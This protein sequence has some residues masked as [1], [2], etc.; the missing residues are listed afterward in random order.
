MILLTGAAGFIGSNLLNHLKAHSD[1]PIAIVDDFCGPKVKNIEST[2][3]DVK[4]H[5]DQ[6][7]DWLVIHG[8]LITEIYHLGARTDTIE[9]NQAIFHQLNLN[10]S[11]RIWN[12]CSLYNV[13]LVYASS[14]ATYGLGELGFMDT[15]TICEDLKPL[16]PY[17]Q[18]KNEFDIWA[19]QQNQQPLFWAGIKFFNVY[20]PNETH[21]GRM[22][23]VI[24][25][26][27]H[28]INQTKGMK[29]FR[30]HRP[31]VKDGYQS[32]DFIY[33]DDIVKLCLYFMDQQPTSGLYNGGTG[34][35][36]T[37]LDLV[38]ATFRAMGEPESIQFIDTP[39]EIRH[40]YQY[41]TEAN[42]KKTWEAGYSEKMLTLEEGV[43]RYVQH[44]ETTI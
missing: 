38:K 28:Q 27:F 6:L 1:K 7:F 33:V 39:I 12:F 37:F 4:I 36:R 31:D 26:A 21:K 18:S 9:K 25:H 15:H 32:R 13:P 41:F 42:M 10:Y 19:L 43:T 5:R 29:L 24:F 14:A 3:Y 22:A 35:A 23:S 40:T 30:S 17:A 44:L 16:N 20:G 11:K 34:E 8:H 2:H